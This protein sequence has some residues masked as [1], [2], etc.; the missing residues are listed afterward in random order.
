MRLTQ[1][2][3]MW[4]KKRPNGNIWIGKKAFKLDP[5]NVD[6]RKEQDGAHS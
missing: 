3:M 1:L 6:V 4:P 2:L 5:D